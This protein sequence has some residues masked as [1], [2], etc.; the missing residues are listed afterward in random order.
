MLI[1]RSMT[2]CII[3]GPL[4]FSRGY[5]LGKPTHFQ[6]HVGDNLLEAAFVKLA[7]GLLFVVRN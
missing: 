4:S 1:S 2:A 7:Q 3:S 6:V 5:P